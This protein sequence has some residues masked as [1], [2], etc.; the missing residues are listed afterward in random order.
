M[1]TQQ[2][3]DGRV[4]LVLRSGDEHY[5]IHGTDETDLVLA[6]ESF[7][8]ASNL[9]HNAA[10]PLDANGDGRVTAS[11]ALMVINEMARQR[12]GDL[13]V[14]HALRQIDVLA[15]RFVD[16]SG[17]GRVTAIDALRIINQMAREQSRLALSA[18]LISPQAKSDEIDAVLRDEELRRLF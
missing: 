2:R 7:A 8:F 14:D 5:R 4:E 9:R 13:A 3:R 6:E 16:T 15:G 17:D 12:E 1:V 11:D 18:E 10:K